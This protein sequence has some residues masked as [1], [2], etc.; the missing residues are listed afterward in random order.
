MRWNAEIL[1]ENILVSLIALPAKMASLTR[2]YPHWHV[3][4]CTVIQRS[5]HVWPV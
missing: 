3:R 5:Q 2:T 4:T 1:I